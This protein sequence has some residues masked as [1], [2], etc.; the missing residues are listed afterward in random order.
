MLLKSGM[1]DSVLLHLRWNRECNGGGSGGR[2]RGDVCDMGVVLIGLLG[3]AFASVFTTLVLGLAIGTLLLLVLLLLLARPLLVSPVWVTALILLALCCLE[4]W[5]IES[6]WYC[7]I[8]TVRM[9]LRSKS[10][11]VL[12]PVT[13][14]ISISHF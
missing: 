13:T 10:S 2:H 9:L 5:R 6:A 4:P 1:S 11:R 12:S 3:F 14:E 8:T 7:M